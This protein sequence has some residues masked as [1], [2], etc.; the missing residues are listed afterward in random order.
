[1][2]VAAIGLLT[3]VVL[4]VTGL[5]AAGVETGAAAMGFFSSIYNLDGDVSGVVI[6]ACIDGMVLVRNATGPSSRFF[7]KLPIFHGKL[8]S[9]L[10]E[11]EFNNG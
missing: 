3:A 1:M 8:N 9:L 6:F 7:S 10:Q 11:V 4:A 5:D 2:F